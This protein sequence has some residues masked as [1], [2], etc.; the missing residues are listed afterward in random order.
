MSDH[1]EKCWERHP[2][3][4]H[5]RIRELERELLSLKQSCFDTQT[6]HILTHPTVVPCGSVGP[7]WAHP[8]DDPPSTTI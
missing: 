2:V 4:A 1:D 5:L 3:C 7:T 8:C 6:G